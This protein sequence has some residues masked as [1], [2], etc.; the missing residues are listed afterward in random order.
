MLSAASLADR[1]EHPLC[2][3]LDELKVFL[4]SVARLSAASFQLF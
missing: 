1:F 4:F 2:F 3:V